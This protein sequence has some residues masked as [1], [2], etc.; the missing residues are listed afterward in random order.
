MGLQGA[1]VF[2]KLDFKRT[3]HQIPVAKEEIHKTAVTTSFGMYEFARLPFGLRNTVQT[4]ARMIDEVLRSLPFTFAYIDNVLI[5][6]RDNAEH[7]NHFEQ[8]F[9]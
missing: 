1:T 4:L 2:T 5:G 8:V 7:C 6:R 3:F 9:Q